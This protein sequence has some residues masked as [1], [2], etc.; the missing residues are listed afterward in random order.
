MSSTASPRI[1]VGVDGSLAGLRALRQAVSEAR[2]RQVEVHAVHV[3][4][5]LPA[6]IGQVG[7]FGFTVPVSRDEYLDSNRLD[8][9]AD[10]V[11]VDSLQHAFGGLPTGVTVRRVVCVGW[12]P[13]ALANLG[14]R[15]GDLLVIGTDGGSR[16]RHPFRRSLSTFCIR[17]AR[18]PVLVVPPDDLAR[19]VRRRIRYHRSALPRHPWTEFDAVTERANHHAG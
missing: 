2:C 12:P 7:M 11:I 17:H 5:V 4:D 14:W 19:T 3:R 1:F 8:S 16:W 6:S 10:A 18:C 15:P 13:R 9:A